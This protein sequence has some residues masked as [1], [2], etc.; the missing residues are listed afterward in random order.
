[1]CS[2]LIFFDKIHGN[3]TDT[4]NMF[5]L[6]IVLWVK[7]RALVLHVNILTAYSMKVYHV[8]D[9]PLYVSHLASLQ[10]RK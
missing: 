5:G 6:Y 3:H 2:F 9:R 7:L 8:N 1:M 4:L 10:E